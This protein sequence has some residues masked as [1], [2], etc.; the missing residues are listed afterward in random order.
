MLLLFQLN[1]YLVKNL[2]KKKSI[3]KSKTGIFF[4]QF[5]S[6]PIRIHGYFG[7]IDWF[8]ALHNVGHKLTAYF[9]LTFIKG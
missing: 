1:S 9:Y 7:R 2:Q 8:L 3:T 5:T 6:F 4:E